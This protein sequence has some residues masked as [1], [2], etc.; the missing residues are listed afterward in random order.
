MTELHF[1]LTAD[2]IARRELMLSCMPD[3][4]PGHAMRLQAEAH[5]LLYG[6]L[7]AEQTRIYEELKAAGVLDG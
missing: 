2:E 3:F 5:A 6:N 7:D 1:D 4:D